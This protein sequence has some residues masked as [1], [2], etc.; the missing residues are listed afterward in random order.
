[1]IAALVEE[2][3]ETARIINAKEGHKPMKIKNHNL[4]DL[5]KEEMGDILFSLSC[6]ANYYQI[7][8]AEAFAKTL[9][10]YTKRDENRWKRKE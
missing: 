6:L 4:N 7:N 1:M 5:L 10:K 9:E 8:L 3:G 2:I